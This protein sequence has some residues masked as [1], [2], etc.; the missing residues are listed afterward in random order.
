MGQLADAIKAKQRPGCKVAELL[1][2][3]P[4]D[5]AADLRLL[6]PDGGV[7]SSALAK[8]LTKIGHAIGRDSIRIHRL[9]ECAC[10]RAR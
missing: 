8:E 7:S 4:K 10:G 1:L 9:G 5:V 6:L 2:A 3:A